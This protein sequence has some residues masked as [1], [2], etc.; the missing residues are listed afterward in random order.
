MGHFSGGRSDGQPT[1]E[2]PKKRQYEYD[3]LGRLTSVC[4]IVTDTTHLTGS[5]TCG[6]NSTQNG[7]WTKYV[8]NMLDRL[9]TVTQ[10]AQSTS[11]QARTFTYDMLGRMTSETNPEAGTTAYAYDVATGP[12][13]A[14]SGDMVYR[15]DQAGNISCYAYDALH[16]VTA[17]TYPTVAANFVTPYARHFQYD[18]ASVTFNGN[19]IGMANAKGRLARAYTCDSSCNWVTDLAFNYSARGEIQDTYQWSLGGYGTYFHLNATYWPHGALNQLSGLPS[20][21]TLY[22]GASDG[23]GLDGEGRVTKVTASSGQNPVTGVTYLANTVTGTC[24]S[25]PQT[26]PVGAITQVNFG[27][28]DSDTFCS[29]AN[30]G[31]M[32]EYNFLVNGVA[33]KGDLTWNNNGS[34]QQL[35]IADSLSGSS[36]SQT[37]TYFHD[38]LGRIG[39]SNDPPPNTKPG[40]NCVQG[41]NTIYTDTFTY[42]AFGNITK[43]GSPNNFTVGYSSANNNHVN[44]IIYDNDGNPAS[45]G[46][47]TSFTWDAEGRVASMGSVSLSYDALGR[48]IAQT[49]GNAYVVVYGPA[50]GKLALVN[51]STGAIIKLFAPLP[52]GATAVY[53]GTALSYYRHA[54]WLGSARMTSSVTHTPLTISNVAY[55]PF[56]ENYDQSGTSDLSFTGQNQDTVS[57]QYDFMF[58][59]YAGQQQGRWISPDPAGLAAVDPSNPQ[60]WNRYAYVGNNPLVSTDSLGLWSDAIHIHSW[61][62][63]YDPFEFFPGALST[64]GGSWSNLQ[65]SGALYASSGAP[66]EGGPIGDPLQTWMGGTI[67]FG[68]WT[69]TSSMGQPAFIGGGAPLAAYIPGLAPLANGAMNAL[70]QLANGIPKKTPPVNLNPANEPPPSETDLWG[71]IAA[72]IGYALRNWTPPNGEFIFIFDPNAIGQEGCK[73]NPYGQTCLTLGPKPPII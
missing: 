59:E 28:S 61:G 42:D 34:L 56:G 26:G 7:Y 33:D 11:T 19:V 60:T 69:V 43:T 2:N 62:Y 35:V 25:T 51:G 46:I 68:Q 55:G 14:Y 67:S 63:T 21:P 32:T 47:G 6:Q 22:Y 16:R 52:G 4:E 15:K 54:D 73:T 58:R 20:M 48:V 41:L 18:A 53:A 10:N 50:G 27:S 65:L 72:K 71:E 39:E 45:N 64:I 36:D 3:A 30:T 38:D 44:G 9:T 17:I 13:A 5:G 29:D 49:G 23:S 70:K 12:C 31:R 37:C 24:P 66:G 40:V 57:G 8:Y 1:G